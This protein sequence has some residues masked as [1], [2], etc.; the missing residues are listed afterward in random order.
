MDCPSTNCCPISR[1]TR[2]TAWRITGSP[3]RLIALRNTPAKPLSGVSRTRPV[4]NKAH[5]DALIKFEWLSPKCL[6]HSEGAILS[7]ISA[8][9]V[10]ESGTLKSAS[11]RHISATPSSEERPYSPKNSS[12]IE[13]AASFLRFSTIMDACTAIALQDGPLGAQATIDLSTL[14]SAK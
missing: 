6:P 5:V 14:S 13:G 4:T 10:V 3:I 2:A 1:I 9:M 12:I 8:S 7:S 11:A